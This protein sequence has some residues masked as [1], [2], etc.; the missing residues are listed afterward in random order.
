MKFPIK[1]VIMLDEAKATA[2]LNSADF[3][4]STL[5]NIC[6]IAFSITIDSNMNILNS[7]RLERDILTEPD[8]TS[9]GMNYEFKDDTL[10]LDVLIRPLEKDSYEGRNAVVFLTPQS[11]IE[12]YTG[13]VLENYRL[14]APYLPR[15]DNCKITSTAQTFDAGIATIDI[16]SQ[17][18]TH[19]EQKNDDPLY[20][21]DDFAGTII[22]EVDSN[23]IK[24]SAVVANGGFNFNKIVA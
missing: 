21:D 1:D 14:R 17:T 9:A 11:V 23:T 5:E 24:I 16:P 13:N 18:V 8:F 2:I 7:K 22:Q 12:D 10:T 15:L 4:N 6:L 20:D 3:K 19:F